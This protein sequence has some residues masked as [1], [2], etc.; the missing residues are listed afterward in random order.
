MITAK[1]ENTTVTRNSSFFKK[2]NQQMYSDAGFDTQPVKE[3]TEDLTDVI[4]DPNFDSPCQ[5]ASKPPDPRKVQ[6]QT[7]PKSEVPAENKSSVEVSREDPSEN[8]KPQPL[9]RSARKRIPRKIFD[10]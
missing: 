10:L 6:N 4:S 8:E 1:N 7:S 3:L 9:R 2:L 5:A